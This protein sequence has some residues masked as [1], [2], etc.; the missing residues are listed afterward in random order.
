MRKLLLIL[1][2]F[3][4]LFGN[5]IAK[6]RL[7]VLDPASI[8]TL[9]MLGAED[10]IVA[11]ANVQKTS[12]WPE[13]KTSKLTS[14]GTFS[15]PSLEK[16]IALK[17]SLVVLSSYSVNLEESLKNYG[18]KSIYLKPK[19]LEDIKENIKI[20]ANL[21]NKKSEG[22]KLLKDFENSLNELKT[23][24]LNK[25]G[26]YLFSSNPLM[27]F[28]KASINSDI[29]DLI[30]IKNLSPNTGVSRPIISS[31]FILKANPDILILGLGVDDAGEFLNAN[32]LI[33]NTKAAKE[34]R[35]YIN[36][37]SFLLMRLSPKITDR[38]KEFKAKL[39]KETSL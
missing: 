5:E 18:I 15:H 37:N 11:I 10:S 4:V 34:N 6:Q 8:E 13:D 2:L 33:K 36:K 35:I 26:M 28:N 16:I 19:R 31:E 14:V 22:E 29:M 21:V 12:I 9:Y 1:G 17:P 27:A 39:S 23:N 7:V 30:G 25:S 20:L 32:P 24:P 38:I 3:G